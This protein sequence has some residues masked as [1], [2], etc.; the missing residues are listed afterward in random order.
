M[1]D[2]QIKEAQKKLEH[3][4]S[5]VEWDID[6]KNT[7][8]YLYQ[9][10]CKLDQERFEKE[11]TQD[12]GLDKIC[13]IN[14]GGPDRKT[15]GPR[16]AHKHIKYNEYHIIDDAFPIEYANKLLSFVTDS[17]DSYVFKSQNN[18]CS[19]LLFKSDSNVKIYKEFGIKLHKELETILDNPPPGYAEIQ[20]TRSGNGDFFGRHTDPGC[21]GN[22]NLFG[23]RVTYIY[24]LL[25]NNNF[26]GGNLILYLNKSKKEIIKPVHNRLVVM[27]P[28]IYHEIDR[29]TCGDN[30]EDGRFTFNG[31]FW[32]KK[33]KANTDI[34]D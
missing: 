2:K 24:Y 20:V 12:L 11:L 33:H 15:V 27:Y 30:F 6:K 16:D 14:V 23:R 4:K 1:N 3:N 21:I 18:R 29:M 31:W 19:Q 25:H 7:L 32:D 34:Y 26:D 8:Y 13:D 5:T 22:R 9:Q 10:R 28:Y 17:K